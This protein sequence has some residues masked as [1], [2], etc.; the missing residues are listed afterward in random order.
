[1]NSISDEDVWLAIAA[2]RC[3][4]PDKIASSV[5]EVVLYT[6]RMLTAFKRRFADATVVPEATGAVTVTGYLPDL[7]VKLF[8]PITESFP[9]CT[10]KLQAKGLPYPRTCR[11]C[12][13]GPCKAEAS[14]PR[15]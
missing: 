13:L 6:D 4:H 7:N 15:S 14:R 1:M 9:N 11:E 2:A 5:D 10:N 8:E 3:Q 12:G